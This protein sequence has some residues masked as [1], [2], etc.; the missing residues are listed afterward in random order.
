MVKVNGQCRLSLLLQMNVLKMNIPAAA[1]VRNLI[2][3]H[4]PVDSVQRSHAFL[5]GGRSHGPVHGAIRFL[6]GPVYPSFT[7]NR[8]GILN[9]HPFIPAAPGSRQNSAEISRGVLVV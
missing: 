3:Y 1:L 7:H 4:H 9:R 5:M 2:L 8:I 6:E